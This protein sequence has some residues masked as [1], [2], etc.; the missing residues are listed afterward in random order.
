MFVEG[1]RAGI[2]NWWLFLMVGLMFDY[3]SGV[4]LFLFVREEKMRTNPAAQYQQP[5][6]NL[7]SAK[8]LYMYALLAAALHLILYRG[9]LLISHGVGFE[10]IG[11]PG[12]LSYFGFTLFLDVPYILF[13]VIEQS[14]R[15][16]A[17][18]WVAIPAQIVFGFVLAIP[19]FLY[20]SEM[21]RAEL[22]QKTSAQ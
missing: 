16:F 13:F 14:R 6:F 19:L 7:Y 12:P 20:L 8:S 21:N 9:F 10:T 2:H 22:Q 3:A 17:Q 15:Q 11:L 18:W 4:M 1:R 5:Q